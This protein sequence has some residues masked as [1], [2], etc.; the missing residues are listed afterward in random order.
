M[1]G[2]KRK[3]LD[4]AGRPLMVEQ[5]EETL[6]EWVLER[7]SNLLRVSRKMIMVKAKSLFDEKHSDPAEKDSFLASTGW[8]IATSKNNYSSERS[9]SRG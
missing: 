4:G 6:V 3:R 1:L 2:A 7:R 8:T 5:F 9:G